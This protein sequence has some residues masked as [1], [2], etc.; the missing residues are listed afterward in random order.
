MTSRVRPELLRKMNE[1]RIL[2]IIRENGPAS[3]AE[4]TRVTGI[5]AP[6]VSKVVAKLIDSRLIEEYVSESPE[7]TLGRPGK[8]LHLSTR[9]A[10]VLGIVIDLKRCWVVASGLDGLLVKE[11]MHK[12][13]TPDS[14][15]ELIE[16]LAEKSMMLMGNPEVKT[17]GIGIS[18]PGLLNTREQRVEFSPNLHQLDG[19]RPSQDL[20][21]RLGVETMMLQ[22]SHALCLAESMFG[23]A[24]GMDDFA[25]F[26]LSSGL[27]LGV[28]SG[29]KIISGHSGLGGEL[30]HI[31]VAPN[32][33]KCG[34]GNHG[35][36]ETVAT[37]T[38]LATAISKSLGRTVDI[39]EAIEL[40][41]SGKFSS[42]KELDQIVEYLAIGVAAVINIFNPSSLFMHGLLFDAKKEL[43]EKVVQ[44]AQSRA[45]GPSV[46]DCVIKRARGSK[47]QG[48]IAAIIS[49]VTNS[50]GPA[51]EPA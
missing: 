30:G 42:T 10:Q 2:E 14:Y 50:L 40:I 1:R 15:Q 35:C 13:P 48:A 8:T 4:V 25:M 9:S 28:M 46:A 36:L 21:K 3:R 11:R 19:Q 5:S 31:T 45:L 47:R 33:A 18:M 38:S 7:G 12:F 37:D 17:L 22:E 26:D 51:L 43:F 49:H 20:S 29:G 23:A 16:Q 27:G 39:E 6:T 24:L 41:K 44:L 32:G 34:C